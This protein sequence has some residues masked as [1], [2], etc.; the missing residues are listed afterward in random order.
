MSRATAPT[1]LP[2]DPLEVLPGRWSRR[3]SLRDGTPVML[4]QIRPEDRARLADG[5]QQLSAASRYQRFHDDVDELTDQQLDYLTDVDHIDHEAIVA[6]DLDHPELPGIGVARSIRDPYQRHVAEAAVTVADRYHGQGA[7]TILLG[8]L[9]SRARTHGIEVFRNHVLFHN[10][11]MLEVFEGL[12]ASRELE[13]DDLWRV[14]LPLPARASD[15]P[16]SPA[17]RAFMAAAKETF[18]ISSLVL[19]VWRLLPSRR[20]SHGGYAAGLDA[21]LAPLAD[22]LDDWLADRDHRATHWPTD[23]VTPPD[24]PGT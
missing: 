7:G 16:D 9:S 10:Q 3:T 11:A 2:D 6:I 20:T 17:G 12:G 19:P 4:R 14:D 23:D 1:T 13:T 5:L 15:L 8:A 24:D 21:G 18:R 22:D